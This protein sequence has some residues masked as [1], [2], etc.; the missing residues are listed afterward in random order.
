MDTEALDRMDEEADGVIAHWSFA[1]LGAKVLPPHFDMLAVWGVFAVVGA[2]IGSFYGV[3]MSRPVL[4]D[5]GVAVANG[6]GGVLAA[7]YV[8]WGFLKYIPGVNVW[9][10]L[11]VQ[12]PVVGAVAYAAGH[13]FKL[14][15]H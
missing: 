4:R 3:Q 9:I 15:Y 7:Y 2:R 10:A 12:P 1:A 13:V 11:L 8:G 6:I 14:Y 5:L